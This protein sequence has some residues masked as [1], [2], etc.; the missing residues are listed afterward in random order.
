MK[1]IGL[2]GRI[3][4]CLGQAAVQHKLKD[5]SQAPQAS[6]ALF[7]VCNTTSAGGPNLEQVVNDGQV[8][9]CHLLAP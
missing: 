8:G 5:A 4:V 7:V 1:T 6:C 3:I 2:A 9:T